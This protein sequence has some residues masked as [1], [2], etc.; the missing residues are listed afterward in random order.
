MRTSTDNYS[1]L[2]SKIDEFIRKYYFNMVVR[3]CFYLL[4]SFFASYVLVALAEY[5]GNFSSLVRTLLFYGFLF[6]NGI[7]L[8]KWI[9]IPLL[10]YYKLGNTISHE[11]AS[12][13]IGQHFADVKD[14]LLN[15]LQLKKLAEENPEQRELIEASIDQ[16]IIELRPVPFSS[17][18]KIK[19]NRKYLR[20]VLPP[21]AILLFIG[22]TA[23][24]ILSE[25]TRRLLKHDQKFVKKAPFQF[26]I[27]NRNLSALQGDD[28]V[29]EVKMTGNEI[30]QD[31]YLED[32]VNSFKLEKENIVNFNYTFR[33]IQNSKEIRLVAG[34]FSSEPCLIK[35]K[36]KPSL[37]NFDIFLQYPAYTGKRNETLSNIGDLKVPAGTRVNWRFKTG[38]TSAM[39]VTMGNRSHN[40]KPSEDNTFNFSYRALQSTEVAIKPLNE[41]ASSN[42]GVSYKLEVIADLSPTIQVNE[43]ADSLNSKMLYFVGQVNDD[44]GFSALRFNYKVL[45]KG[46][47]FKTI[48]KQLSVGRNAVQSNFFHVWNLKDAALNPGEQIEY[49]F[50]IVDND[51]VNG[52]KTT[53]SEIKTYRLP[54]ETETEKKIEQTSR[55]IEHK[56]EQ[57]IRQASHV[58]REAKKLHQELLNKKNLSFD[59]KKQ[60]EQLL[61]KQKDLERLVNEVKQENKQNQLERQDLREQNKEI[62]EKQKQ[63]E[64]LLNNVLDEKTKELLKNIEKLLEQNNKTQTQQ[65]LSK[66]QADNKTLQKELDRILE[67]YKQLEFDQKLAETANKLEDL[68]KKQEVLKN[69]TDNAAAQSGMQ[70]LKN[71]QQEINEQFQDVKDDLKELEEKN[72]ELE[73]KNDFE[74]PKEEQNQIENQLEQSEKNLQSKNSKKAADNQKNAAQQMRQLSKK[75]EQM[76]Q[77]N[78]QE[79]NQVNMQNLREILDNLLTS[80][81]D[82]EKVMQELRGISANDPNYVRLTQKQ[83][84]IKDNLRTVQDS[85]YALSKKAPQIESVINKEIQAINQNIDA[86]LTHLGERR[87]SEANR[88][89]QYAMT[90]IN[91]LALMLSEVQ[92][93][94]QRMMQNA[95]QGGKGKQKSLSQLSKMQEELNKNMQRARQQMQQQGQQQGQQS[96]QRAQGKGP[97]SEQLAKMAREQQMIRQALQEI[98]R[99]LNKDGKAGLGNLDKLAKEME[100]SEADLVHKKIQQE[101]LIRQQEI[102][103]KLL[104]AEKADRERELDTQRE[105]NQGRDQAP[106]YKIVLEEFKK[107]KQGEVE[108]LKTV[109][110][111]LNSFY[112]LKVGDYFR[113]LNTK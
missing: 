101:T 113:L 88:N 21:L 62:L 17:A 32:G 86:A 90:S 4:A 24:S 26:N 52:P 74:N 40:I 3:G 78:E 96:A 109:P 59:E 11:K 51:A 29:L 28:F 7:I 71:E 18:I 70:Q 107:L 13:I 27:V 54:S 5:F 84:D 47:V 31:I 104:E 81:F 42:E 55:A 37:L 44:Y 69:K 36:K 79:E 77:E 56:M 106:N 30:P 15:T 80:S 100:Q 9:I 89:Q 103:T 110:P 34:E 67:L 102:L 22:A 48:S 45:D 76:Q 10:S 60:V 95:Q 75:L 65:E 53:R 38:N 63:I 2:L 50:E 72:Q 112:K 16:K 49:Y 83:K 57:A 92:E 35:V 23:P 91:N 33:N 68:A 46:K 93:Q 58:E 85:L 1:Y 82:Q 8:S 87:T 6:L 111:S 12:A 99:D 64:D 43:R 108:L 14:K 41:D 20:F 98:N 66:M 19:E 25:S 61:Q 73:K 97:M 39:A 94:L 105:S